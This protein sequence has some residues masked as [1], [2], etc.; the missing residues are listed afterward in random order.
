IGAFIIAATGVPFGLGM[1]SLLPFPATGR[2][3]RGPDRALRAGAA[4]GLGGL[5]VASLTLAGMLL[6]GH[7]EDRV[8]WAVGGLAAATA[9]LYVLS[10]LGWLPGIQSGDDPANWDTP[11]TAS[12]PCSSRPA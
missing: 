12:A 1:V 3:A 10:R 9:L 11:R 6:R 5:A 4:I 7:D 2:T 8:W